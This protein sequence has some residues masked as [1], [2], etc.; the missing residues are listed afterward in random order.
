MNKRFDLLLILST[1]IFLNS[2]FKVERLILL[3]IQV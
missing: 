3:N 2:L 1:V